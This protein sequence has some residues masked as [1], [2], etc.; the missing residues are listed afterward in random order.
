MRFNI[1]MGILLLMIVTSCRKENIGGSTGEKQFQEPVVLVESSIKGRIVDEDNLPLQDVLVTVKGED[2]AITQFTDENGFFNYP[3]GDFNKNGQYI[4]AEKNGYFLGAKVVNPNLNETSFTQIKLLSMD[5][6]GT[7]NTSAGGTITTTDGARVIFTENAIVDNSGNTYSGPVDVFVKWIDPSSDDIAAEMPGD[8]RAVNTDEEAVQL[9]TYG[10]L[11]VELRSTSGAELNLADG[12]TAQLTFPLPNNLKESAPS[13]IPLWSFNEETGYWE[14]EGA[15]TFQDGQYVGDVSHFSFWN[16]DAPF[17]LVVLSGNVQDDSGNDLV[18]LQLAITVDG[19]GTRYGYI[20]DEGNFSGKVP[21]N[22]VL[23]FEIKDYCGNVL[24]ESTYGPY[25]E[26]TD[27]GTITISSITSTTIIGRLITCDGA[28]VTNGYAYIDIGNQSFQE[29]VNE[30]GEFTLS[31]VL[32]ETVNATVKGYD[33]DEFLQSD[34]ITI[35][36]PGDQDLGDITVCDEI[37]EY[38]KVTVIDPANEQF[39]FDDLFASFDG[40]FYLGTTTED[41]TYI[42]MQIEVGSGETGTFNVLNADYYS[43]VSGT[44]GLYGSCNS[45]CDGATA[46]ITINDASTGR[47]KGIAELDLILNGQGSD[48]LEVIIEWDLTSN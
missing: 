10:M 37:T 39:V 28:A 12:K 25:T 5:L 42:N 17:P 22:E 46:D 29:T 11:A 1:W 35:S 2:Q 43:F 14:E 32:C 4:T 8:L 3:S 6:T 19:I 13:T 45:G 48:I 38:I 9:A 30:N 36:T 33:L 26:D 15:A 20:N 7:F 18:Y 47:V 16:C 44:N 23:N 24:F 31:P 40:N 21:K 34:P 27:I 41:S